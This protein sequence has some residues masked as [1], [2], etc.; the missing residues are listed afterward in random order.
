[1]KWIQY[2]RISGFLKIPQWGMVFVAI[3]KC[4]QLKEKIIIMI[5]CTFL[6]RTYKKN[7]LYMAVYNDKRLEL[8]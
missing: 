4:L 3:N 5:K 2:D 1:M 6:K 8:V 7:Y